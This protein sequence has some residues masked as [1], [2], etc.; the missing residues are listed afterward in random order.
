MVIIGN[1]LVGNLKVRNHSG[2]LSEIGFTEVK[3]CCLKI[4]WFDYAY[5]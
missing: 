1:V 4:F 3:S 5:L 2:N